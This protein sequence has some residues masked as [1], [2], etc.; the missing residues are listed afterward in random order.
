MVHVLK[1]VCDAHDDS[2]PRR[3][4]QMLKF[5]DCKK[6]CIQVAGNTYAYELGGYAQ[7]KS[8]TVKM[9]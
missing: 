4:V 7:V 1:A 2:H 5:F 6:Q 8:L 3:P 9:L